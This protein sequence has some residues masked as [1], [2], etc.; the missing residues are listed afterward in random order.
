[1]PPSLFPSEKRRVRGS[2]PL[3]H[4]FPCKKDFY[5]LKKRKKIPHLYTEVRWRG[6]YHKPFT[7]KETPFLRRLSPIN[8]FIYIFDF[9]F[10]TGAYYCTDHDNTIKSSGHGP[11]FWVT[12]HWKLTSS[13]LVRDGNKEMIYQHLMKNIYTGG[14]AA[15]GLYT[16]ETRMTTSHHSVQQL[17]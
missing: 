12:A 2:P 8:I 4:F 10:V 13:A 11:T 17:K 3:S 1:M 7:N 6:C 15:H 9:S 16:V 5:C 14:I